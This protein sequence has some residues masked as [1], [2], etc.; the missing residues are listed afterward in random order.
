MNRFLESST[1]AAHTLVQELTEAIGTNTDTD[2]INN[3]ELMIALVADM[4]VCL[5]KMMDSN[6]RK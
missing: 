2:V 4:E 3:L 6:L 1:I 5:N